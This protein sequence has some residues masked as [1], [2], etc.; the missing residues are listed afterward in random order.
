MAGHGGRPVATEPRGA[1]RWGPAPPRS[2]LVIGRL[3]IGPG[4]VVLG[5]V[6]VGRRLTPMLRPL[7]GPVLVLGG[8]VL[9]PG[10]VGLGWVL[11]GRRLAPLLRLL[12]RRRRRRL[13]PSQRPSGSRPIATVLEDRVDREGTVATGSRLRRRLERR[14]GAEDD[15]QARVVAEGGADALLLARPAQVGRAAAS[16]DDGPA[17]SHQEVLDAALRVGQRVVAVTGAIAVGSSGPRSV[18]AA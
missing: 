16:R 9:G 12:P 4:V 6:L 13:G 11:V 18:R 17:T 10:V 8:L 3:V 1:R 14:V 15:E 2:V 5:R 7:L